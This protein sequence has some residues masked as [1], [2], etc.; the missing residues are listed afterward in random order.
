MD[1]IFGLI[2][3]F[4]GATNKSFQKYEPKSYIKEQKINLK[5]TNIICFSYK[6][7]YQL[8]QF[9]LSVQNNL[10]NISEILV[11]YKVEDEDNYTKE[12]YDQV[13][14]LFPVVKAKKETCFFDD[15]KA[16]V[17]YL[18]SKFGSSSSIIFCVD[19]MIFSS[20]EKIRSS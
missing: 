20:F 6:R 8:Q 19:D 17:N 15:T 2:N 13:F 12:L 5:T 16:S 7:P 3:E 11:I 14:Q 18:E 10:N 9:L 1:N 4:T